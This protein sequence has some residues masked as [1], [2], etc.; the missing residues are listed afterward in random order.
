MP[1]LDDI[2]IVS[3]ADF[4]STYTSAYHLKSA[5]EKLAANGITFPIKYTSPFFPQLNRLAILVYFKGTVTVVASK[6][7]EDDNFDYAFAHSVKLFV[8]DKLDQIWVERKLAPYFSVSSITDNVAVGRNR[9]SWLN[10]PLARVLYCMEVPT[11]DEHSTAKRLPPF[12]SDLV[13]FAPNLEGREGELAHRLLLDA[14]EAFLNIK[15]NFYFSRDF[16]WEFFL[17]G[18]CNK[19]TATI[20]RNSILKLLTTVFPGIDFLRMGEPRKKGGGVSIASAYD[21]IIGLRPPEVEKLLNNYGHLLDLEEVLSH[22]QPLLDFY[23]AHRDGSTP[24]LEI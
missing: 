13:S 2:V 20:F 23:L 1:S 6:E 5:L 18:K 17:S 12:I 11:P 9:N 22:R 24:L 14:C 4:A 19:A 3:E 15:L 10:R 21:S 8:A 7:S 16:D